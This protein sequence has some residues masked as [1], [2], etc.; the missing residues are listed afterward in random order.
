M[1]LI[2][3]FLSRLDRKNI[4]DGK[5]NTFF[6]RYHV[7]KC[8]WFSIFLHEFM[9]SDSDRC[10]HDHPWPFISI[11]LRGGYTEQMPDGMHRRRP[12]S[13]LFRRANAAHRIEID[14]DTRPWSLVIVGRKSRDWGFFT[15][16]GWEAWKPGASPICETE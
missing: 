12:G 3:K 7:F 15:L 16:H 9:R 6:L 10:L 5:G 14:P 4:G 13:I 1:G 11:V 2:S 8:R